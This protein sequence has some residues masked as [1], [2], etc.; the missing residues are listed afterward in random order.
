MTPQHPSRNALVVFHGE[1]AGGWRR[2]LLKPGF[3]Q[4]FAAVDSGGWW[5]LFDPR[6]GRVELRLLARSDFDLAAFCR[7]KSYA[8][9]ELRPG[10]RPPRSPLMPATCVGAVKR[11][12]GLRAPFAQTP[13]R[14]WRH[15]S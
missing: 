4:C 14:L 11:L 1:G 3:R 7:E 9:A 12:L 15:L 2:R 5:I 10:T 8:V 13:W 6:D